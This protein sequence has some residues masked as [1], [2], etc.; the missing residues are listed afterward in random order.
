MLMG[1][2][3]IRSHMNRRGFKHRRSEDIFEIRG[4]Y[5]RNLQ[6]VYAKEYKTR[7]GTIV[8]LV[9][10]AVDIFNEKLVVGLYRENAE[11]ENG[12]YLNASRSL[13]L[14]KFNDEALRR[15]LDKLIVPIP[16][17]LK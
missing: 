17:V 15:E 4:Q 14:R 7:S 5:A 10:F 11:I 12:V 3:I 8:D 1:G 9:Y 6:Y 16:D 13:T 2:G